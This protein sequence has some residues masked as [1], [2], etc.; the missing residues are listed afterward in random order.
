MINDSKSRLLATSE[1][2]EGEA[3]GAGDKNTKRNEKI[4]GDYIR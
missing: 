1:D 4:R 2:K 3:A